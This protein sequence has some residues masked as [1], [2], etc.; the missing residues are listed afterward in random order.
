M[1]KITDVKKLREQTQAPVMECRKALIEVKGDF[2]KA[3]ELLKRWGVEKIETKKD[4]VTDQGLVASY[5]HTNGKIGALVSLLCETDFV[6]RT[7]EFKTLVREI[8][9]QVAAM[10]PKEVKALL[11]QEYI[12]DSGKTIDQLVKEV[13]AKVGENVIVKR[14]IR[15]ELGNKSL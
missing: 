11:K 8:A 7:D 10:N 4:R 1:V 14:F 9:M 2:A 12:R 13:I 5:I 3:K 6:A 15:F